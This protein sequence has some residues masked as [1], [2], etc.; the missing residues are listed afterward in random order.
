MKGIMQVLRWTREVF[1]ELERKWRG[2]RIRWKTACKL[3]LE[4]ARVE[5]LARACGVLKDVKSGVD[6][7]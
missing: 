1:A 3:D 6:R 2:V 5:A 4:C 7:G